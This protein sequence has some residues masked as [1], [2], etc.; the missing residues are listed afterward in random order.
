MLGWSINCFGEI[1][2]YRLY[3]TVLKVH[4]YSTDTNEKAVLEANPDW[5]YEGAVWNGYESNTGQYPVYRLYSPVLGKHLFTMDEN[6][7]NVL[8][9]GPNWQFEMI[10]W[11]ANA[12]PDTGDIPIYRLY[13]DGL[14]QHLYTADKNEK[15]TLDG[16]GVWVYEGIAYY[17]SPISTLAPDADNNKIVQ[18][19]TNET[20]YGELDDLEPEE[21]SDIRLSTDSINSSGI[22]ETSKKKFEIT[23]T[24]EIGS[25]L[26]GNIDIVLF[27]GNTVTDVSTLFDYNSQTNKL[28]IPENKINNFYGLLG[29]DF[30]KLII[31]GQDSLGASFSRTI[32][33]LYGFGQINGTLVND[34]GQPYLGLEGEKVKLSGGFKGTTTEVSIEA[35]S[36]FSFRDLP[37]D[38]YNL[39]LITDNFKI[40]AA[41]ILIS[42]DSQ[43]VEVTPQ[44]I[45]LKIDLKNKSPQIVKS[46]KIAM[47]EVSQKR[48][49]YH[50]KMK[51]KLN[52]AQSKTANNEE[53]YGTITVTSDS[54]G[55]SISESKNIEIP[56]GITEIKVVATVISAEFPVWTT[57]Q[58]EYNDAWQYIYSV[59]SQVEHQ[60]GNVNSTHASTDTITFNKTFEI[61][62]SSDSS[63]LK[64]TLFASVTNI[65]DS[66]IPTSVTLEV[67]KA[68]KELTVNK[69][70]H[71]EGL[72]YAKDRWHIGVGGTSHKKWSGIVE[73]SPKDSELRSAEC[74]FVTSNIRHPIDHTDIEIESAG[75][76]MLKMGFSGSGDFT[77]WVSTHGKIECTFEAFTVE[78]DIITTNE[79]V[80]MKMESGKDDLIPLTRYSFGNRYGTRDIGGDDWMR[81]R[82]RSFM[83]GTGSFLIYNDASREHGGCFVRDSHYSIYNTS[84]SSGCSK[85]IRDHASH[86]AGTSIDALY[87]TAVFISPANLKNKLAQA[88]NTPSVADEI[89]TWV[90]E[91]R[92]GIDKITL[93]DDVEL[94]YIAKANWMKNLLIDGIDESGNAMKGLSEWTTKS[95]KVM[96]YGGHRDHIHIEFLP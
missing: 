52:I 51:D 67:Y 28:S 74:D 85:S 25:I 10:A 72:G 78:N 84:K 53:L 35:G 12:T 59:G 16:N 63:P 5:N 44:V 60:Q 94:V 68:E 14:K 27:S 87:P 88:S 37:S 31:N 77:S 73:Y 89:K 21:E 38:T 49:D 65:G 29:S 96:P 75:K 3:N 66:I 7:K 32:T 8:N 93:S 58:S 30:I 81:S 86:R 92:S 57:V 9:A 48:L 41:S 18:V 76:A 13:S 23:L 50:N 80:N 34:N 6:E 40:A 62:Q 71:K 4:L 61:N 22:L 91:A 90:T 55:F 11:Y 19:V 15:D 42:L 82:T 56:Q 45:D 64:V 47:N 95:A 70:I 46:A 69:F 79:P 39:S 83:V 2:V 36:R 24:S 26:E 33:F 54:E 20:E 1:P 43:S 17:T